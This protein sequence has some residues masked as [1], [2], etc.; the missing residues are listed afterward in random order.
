MLKTAYSLVGVILA[1]AAVAPAPKPVAAPE[2]V[3]QPAATAAG[4]APCPSPD[5]PRPLAMVGGQPITDGDVEAVAGPQLAQVRVQEGMIRQQ[6]LND[7]ISRKII[8]K[9]AAAGG[10]SPEQLMRQVSVGVTVTDADV[11]AFY[12]Q[13]KGEFGTASEADALRQ[14]EPRLLQQRQQERQ[15]AYV[16]ELRAK[17]GV[18][19]LMEPTRVQVPTDGQTRGAKSA[20]VTIVEFS[21]FQCPYCLR[22]RPAVNKIREVYGDQV[23]WVYKDFPLEFHSNARKAAEAARCAGEQGKFW[24]MYDSLFAHQTELDVAALKKQA[25]SVGL[26]AARFD[27]CLDSGRHAEGIKRDMA[28]AQKVGVS[29]TPSYFVNGR[30]LVGARP[31]QDFAA[32]IDDEIERASTRR[33]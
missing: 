13:H 21:D 3:S 26:T 7:L 12:A 32:V 2:A 22:V 33:P 4:A 18:K 6:A 15:M 17:A 1:V 5:A 28:E 19:I 24:E 29:G 16:R 8:E 27:E 11:K 30:A 31:F 25:A 9:A 10:T 23:R 14:I 20:P